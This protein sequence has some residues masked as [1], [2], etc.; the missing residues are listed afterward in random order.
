MDQKNY[1]YKT[2]NIMRR[3][4]KCVLPDFRRQCK[5][6]PTITYSIANTRSSLDIEQLYDLIPNSCNIQRLAGEDKLI[7]L[8]KIR[9]V[10]R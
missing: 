5:H 2:L 6:I 10:L 9:M 4:V 3:F 1:L 8:S 7:S